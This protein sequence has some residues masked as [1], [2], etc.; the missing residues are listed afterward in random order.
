MA[1]KW[2]IVRGAV[3]Q[4]ILFPSMDEFERYLQ[5]LDIKRQDYQVISKSKPSNDGSVLVVMR[6]R[7]NQNKFM[8]KND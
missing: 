2:K 3:E 1:W 8:R 6:K 7:Y 4:E 5:Y